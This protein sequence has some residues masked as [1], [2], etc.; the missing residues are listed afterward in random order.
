MEAVKSGASFGAP[1]GGSPAVTGNK[2][3]TE[4]SSPPAGWDPFEVWRT[5]VRDVQK[6]RVRDG[7]PSGKR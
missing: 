7:S 6:A 2:P 3:A 4:G 5:R 1:R